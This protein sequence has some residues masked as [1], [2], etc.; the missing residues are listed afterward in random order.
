MLET[1]VDDAFNYQIVSSNVDG[2]QYQIYM[3][4]PPPTELGGGKNYNTYLPLGWEKREYVN[5]QLVQTISLTGVSIVGDHSVNG[6]ILQTKTSAG[7]AFIT[8][9]STFNN[10]AAYTVHSANVGGTQKDVYSG[11][12]ASI[13]PGA[14]HY[15]FAT[16]SGSGQNI[17]HYVQGVLK[18]T[19]SSTGLSIVGDIVAT[20]NITG[21]SITYSTSTSN[22]FYVNVDGGIYG[23]TTIDGSDGRYVVFTSA[24]GDGPL[25]SGRIVAHGNERPFNEGNIDIC[26]GDA[27]LGTITFK[28]T[29]SGVETVKGYVQKLGNLVW[30]Q[31]VICNKN[32]SVTG[33]TSGGGALTVQGQAQ[34]GS[35]LTGGTNAIS[36]Q[37]RGGTWTPDP[38]TES[39]ITSIVINSN[40][41]T[42]RRWNNMVFIRV[43]FTFGYNNS[44][45]TLT[46]NQVFIAGLP[47]LVDSQ[48]TGKMGGW[49]WSGAGSHATNSNTLTP[50]PIHEFSFHTQPDG[51][52]Y[53]GKTFGPY[54]FCLCR[55]TGQ[56]GKFWYADPTDATNPTGQSFAGDFIYFTN[57]A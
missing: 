41:C 21:G 25:R 34:V 12:A 40:S 15:V 1:L 10:V 9:K 6:N 4:I 17:L 33:A 45:F 50:N 5:S 14:G 31:D 44:G 53:Q 55:G 56:L 46:Q 28:T 22:N 24:N 30:E 51:T 7:N 11:I 18:S 20:G 38:Q 42:W 23:G 37:F 36:S 48:A 2:T 19:L 35:L 52:T 8:N 27:V 43:Q 32:L 39:G 47:F 29:I 13:D 49:N 57:D 16:A 54:Q 26:A 3:G